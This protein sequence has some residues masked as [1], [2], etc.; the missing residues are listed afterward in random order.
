MF[1]NFSEA[2]ENK[3]RRSKLFRNKE[4]QTIGIPKLFRSKEEQTEV[5]QS[6]SGTN[7]IIPIL[8]RTKVEQSNC[9]KN[10]K[11]KLEYA[12]VFQKGSKWNKKNSPQ[13]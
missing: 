13:T 12:K 11:I 9:S 2:K 10:F 1:Q 8:F 6:F 7:Q 4:E 3:Q 5:F